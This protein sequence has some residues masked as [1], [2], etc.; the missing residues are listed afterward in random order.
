MY[1][2]Q[3]FD[4]CVSERATGVSEAFGTI[5]ANVIASEK[6]SDSLKIAKN[7]E[8][9][10]GFFRFSHLWNRLGIPSFD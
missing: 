2:L 4:L 6:S 10:L 7:R 3:D 5:S 9:K 8:K 1:T